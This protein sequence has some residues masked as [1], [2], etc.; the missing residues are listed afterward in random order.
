MDESKV[1][2]LTAKIQSLREE[3]DGYKREAKRIQEEIDA[4]DLL[5]DQAIMSKSDQTRLDLVPPDTDKG[6]R[7]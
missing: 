5:R 2:Q 1:R 3:R 6:E 7:G 4:I